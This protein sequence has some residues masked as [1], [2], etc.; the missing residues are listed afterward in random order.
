VTD[1]RPCRQVVEACIAESNTRSSSLGTFGPSRHLVAMSPASKLRLWAAPRADAK[2]L[3]R[4]RPCEMRL[5]PEKLKI[6]S[7]CKEKG[8]DLS[9]ASK[10]DQILCT[11]L[12]W[13]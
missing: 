5:V 10:V 11:T 7:S 9:C 3:R 6:R 4:R 13:L 8:S 1:L 12:S 2:W